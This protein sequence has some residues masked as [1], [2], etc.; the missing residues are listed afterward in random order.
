MKKKRQA[1]LVELITRYEINTQDE[2]IALLRENGFDVTQATVSR[3][4]RE[5]NIFKMIGEDGSYRYSPPQ[6]KIDKGD[7]VKNV[8]NLQSTLVKAILKVDYAGNLVVVRTEAGLAQAVAVGIDRLDM[9]QLLGCVAGDD[10]I[11]IAVR[12]VEDAA[13]FSQTIHEKLGEG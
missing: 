4:I 10:T 7:G 2:L 6:R 8:S 5:L 3:D 12:A 9:P 13:S 1:K 11:L